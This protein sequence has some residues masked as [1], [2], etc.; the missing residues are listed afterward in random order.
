MEGL[1]L[2]GPLPPWTTGALSNRGSALYNI[3]RQFEALTSWRRA[4]E[5]NPTDRNTFKNLASVTGTGLGR[6]YEANQAL[7]HAVVLA[8]RDGAGY[9]Q[10]ALGYHRVQAWR[11]AV[12]NA[13][14]ALKLVPN[15]F[16]AMTARCTATREV[17]PQPF[18]FTPAP[19]SHPP[20]PLPRSYTAQLCT[21][22]SSPHSCKVFPRRLAWPNTVPSTL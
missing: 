5:V 8:P 19:P 4:V 21:I 6:W 14:L 18:P 22:A 12:K 17:G 20:C 3:D 15:D 10:L 11:R 1:A 7:K 16:S 2:P 13:E 9:S